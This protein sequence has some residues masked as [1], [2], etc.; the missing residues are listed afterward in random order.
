MEHLI[1]K[2]TGY[3]AGVK[4]LINKPHEDERGSFTRI[5]CEREFEKIGFKTKQINWSVTF[6]TGTFRGLH[7]QENQAKIVRCISGAI[8]DVVADVRKESETRGQYFHTVLNDHEPNCALYIPAG[9][10][11]GFQCLTESA[12][13]MYLASEFYSKETEQGV[14]W[15]DPTFSIHWPF[16]PPKLVSPK[17]QGFPSFEK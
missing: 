13:I 8:F 2:D 9:C 3:V 16:Y 11:H 1:I 14:R 7:Y 12:T 17:D 15:N 6:G 5:Y 4:F 10:A